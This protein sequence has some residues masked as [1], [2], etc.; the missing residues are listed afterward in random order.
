MRATI[1]G[2]NGEI[3]IDDRWHE[4]PNL[5]LVQ[6]KVKTPKSFNFLGTWL[7]I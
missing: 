1:A 2:E 6:S 5:T 7:F 4:S 3:Y